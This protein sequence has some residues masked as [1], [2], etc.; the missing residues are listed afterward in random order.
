MYIIVYSHYVWARPMLTKGAHD[1]TEGFRDII[2]KIKRS[3]R[4]VFLDKVCLLAA[5]LRVCVC[6][7]LCVSE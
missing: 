3:P 1:V 4:S 2:Q 7:C 6:V 5:C